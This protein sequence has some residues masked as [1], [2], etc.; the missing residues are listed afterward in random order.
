MD[1]LS[2]GLVARLSAAAEALDASAVGLVCDRRDAIAVAG[3]LCHR[4]RGYSFDRLTSNQRVICVRAVLDILDVGS[5]SADIQIAFLA[6]AVGRPILVGRC[7]MLTWGLSRSE[8]SVA[9]LAS[10]RRSAK[11]SGPAIAHR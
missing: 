5:H 1:R 10:A 4:F 9:A 7:V 2:A 11:S 6:N 3:L 8:V